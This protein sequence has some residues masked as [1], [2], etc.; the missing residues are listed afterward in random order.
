MEQSVKPTTAS[1]LTSSPED[2]RAAAG[3]EAAAALAFNS[4]VEEQPPLSLQS[5]K[6]PIASAT[7]PA[8]VPS[9]QSVQS[10]ALSAAEEAEKAVAEKAAQ[11]KELSAMALAEIE[12][13]AA[14]EK[15]A[16]V[17]E[18]TAPQPPPQGTKAEA[19]ERQAAERQAAEQAAKE[20]ADKVLQEKAAKLAELGPEKEADQQQLKQKLHESNKTIQKKENVAP[21]KK[22]SNVKQN[23]FTIF[24]LASIVLTALALVTGGMA[25]IAG[26]IISGTFLLGSASNISEEKVEI[27]EQLSKKST[28]KENETTRTRETIN[29][30]ELQN[31]T[32][33][34]EQVKSEK[35]K[36]KTII[37]L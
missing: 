22:Q 16:A 28:S 10:G 14:R 1:P 15:E 35:D 31:R 25:F 6:P 20:A 23:I 4:R 7:P 37:S 12:T 24:L 33:F 19:A 34:Q 9:E 36:S 3:K 32:T 27:N 30:P 17:A 8:Q 29:A 18:N 26:A 21:T 13:R 2:A 5:V 11:E